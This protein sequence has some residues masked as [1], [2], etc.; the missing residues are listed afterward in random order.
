[1]GKPIFN[2]K[3]EIFG[4]AELKFEHES[5]GREGLE[6]RSW[7]RITGAFYTPLGKRIILSAKAW[8]PFAYKENHP[9]ILDYVGLG[10]IKVEHTV[11][12]NRL[13]ADITVRKGLVGWKGSAS[14]R[15]L[16]KLFNNTGNQYLMMEW[17]AGYSESLI[18]YNRYTS[19]VRIGY[20]IKSNYLDLLNTK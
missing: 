1:M 17:F 10:E 13:I 2:K 3:G 5:N 4:I 16:Y 7:N 8:V 6:S 12:S 14:T 19:M 20:V 11:I 9:D 15:I 18:D